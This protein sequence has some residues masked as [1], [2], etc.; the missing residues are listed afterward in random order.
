MR[1]KSALCLA[2][3]LFLSACAR[4]WPVVVRYEGGMDNPQEPLIVTVQEALSEE[5]SSVMEGK[6]LQ[7]QLQ[8]APSEARPVRIIVTSAK[9]T[10]IGATSFSVLGPGGTYIP[11]EGQLGVLTIRHDGTCP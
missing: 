2:G 9:G 3:L 10:V 5:M 8:R 7:L 1:S 4:P 11:V 6:C